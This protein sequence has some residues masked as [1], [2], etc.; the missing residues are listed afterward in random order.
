MFGKDSHV[1]VYSNQ[2]TIFA[3][4]IH[5]DG[6]SCWLYRAT[7]YNS[8]LIGGKWASKQLINKIHKVSGD[9]CSRTV[10]SKCILHTAGCCKSL[11]GC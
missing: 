5:M 10:S 3:V 7:L 9:K 11:H 2:I 6:I 4:M 1:T 8:I